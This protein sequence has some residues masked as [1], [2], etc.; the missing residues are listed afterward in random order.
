MQSQTSKKNIR[1]TG[2]EELADGKTPANVTSHH[3]TNWKKQMWK[4]QMYFF[5]FF[6]LGD[7][8]AFSN[9]NRQENSDI[10]YRSTRTVNNTLSDWLFLVKQPTI[11]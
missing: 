6:R 4:K 7:K 9:K 10:Q 11:I 3:K 1:A 8:N 2:V 5:I